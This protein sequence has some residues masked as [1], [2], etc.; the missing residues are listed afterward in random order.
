MRIAVDAMGGDQGP[1]AVVGGVLEA[2]RGGA[3]VVLVGN[4]SAIRSS[5]ER[6]GAHRRRE[7]ADIEVLDAPEVVEMD[8]PA[9]TPIRVKR[10]SSVRLAAELVREGK[11]QAALSFGNTGATLACGKLVIG[12]LPGVDRP[13]L[14]AVFPNRGGRTVLLDVG[15]N[16][17]SRPG[18]LRQFAV[19]GHF[20]AQEVLGTDS[21]RVGLLSIGEENEKG[22]GTTRKVF[23]LMKTMGL[24]FVGNVEGGDIFSGTADVIVCDGFVG[25]VVLK[26][27]ES[28]ADLFGDLLRQELDASVRTRLGAA[29]ARP[30]LERLRTSVDYRE[31]GAVPLLGLRGGCFVGHGNSGPKAVRNA[32][33]EAVDFCA[34]GLHNKIR[35]KMEELHSEENRILS[36]EEVAS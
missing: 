15:A 11:A 20:Y 7:T 31:T 28:A 2:V 36:P 13:A 33:R 23:E 14:A 25:N 29:L 35:I 32:I 4:E 18:H 1:A 24:N 21:P 12:A 9:I 8:E 30:A 34:A 19:M 26:S 27:S 17:D 3:D 5:L 22:S 10:R 6:H 16:V